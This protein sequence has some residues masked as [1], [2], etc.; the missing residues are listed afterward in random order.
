MEYR[1]FNERKKGN[2]LDKLKGWQTVRVTTEEYNCQDGRQLLST[3][4]DVR[5]LELDSA[6]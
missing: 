6:E 2:N 5:N 3:D 1:I 4:K